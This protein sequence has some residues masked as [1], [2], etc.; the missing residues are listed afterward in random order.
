MEYEIIQDRHAG[1][2]SKTIQDHLQDGWVLHGNLVI[3][4]DEAGILYVQAV[5]RKKKRRVR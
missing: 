5:T 2:L 1:G 4:S 3:I